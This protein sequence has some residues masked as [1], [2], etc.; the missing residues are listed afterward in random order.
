ME[1]TGFSS[2]WV[3]DNKHLIRFSTVGGCLR[4]KRTDV[5]QLIE[6]NYFKAQRVGRRQVGLNYYYMQEH[7]PSR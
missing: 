7:V 1:L 3:N 5:E 6:E 2:K 4:F